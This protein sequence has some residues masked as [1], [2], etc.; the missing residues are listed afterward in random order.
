MSNY[1]S[2]DQIVDEHTK[3]IV[4]SL[5]DQLEEGDDD[6]IKGELEEMANDIINHLVDEIKRM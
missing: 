1:Y 2:I 6:I 3:Y 4:N 5:N